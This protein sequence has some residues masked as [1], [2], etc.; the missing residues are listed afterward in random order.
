MRVVFVGL[1]VSVA[2]LAAPA[3]VLAHPGQ[4]RTDAEH[5]AED[6]APHDKAAEP[7]LTRR[8]RTA[9]AADALAAAAAVVGNEHEVGIILLGESLQTVPSGV[10]DHPGLPF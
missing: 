3:F 1:A 5:F 7:Q 6:S 8:T 10:S 9:T 4:V 2:L